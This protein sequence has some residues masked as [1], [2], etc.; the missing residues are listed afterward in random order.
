MILA[1]GL[2]LVLSRRVRRES[3]RLAR[4][5]GG[6]GRRQAQVLAEIQVL[7]RSARTASATF[8]SGACA[9]SATGL[10]L[11]SPPA[12]QNRTLDPAIARSAGVWLRRISAGPVGEPRSRPKPRADTGAW[13]HAVLISAL[14]NPVLAH[15]AQQI[16]FE[17]VPAIAWGSGS[18]GRHVHSS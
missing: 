14:R 1:I 15:G 2:S 10:H 6:W 16:L 18:E 8:G 5:P 3:A 13:Q 7:T 11:V 4:K 9:T 17:A 12:L